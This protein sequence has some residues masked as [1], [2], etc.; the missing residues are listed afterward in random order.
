MTGTTRAAF[1]IAMALAYAPAFIKLFIS[2]MISPMLLPALAQQGIWVPVIHLGFL[3]AATVGFWG[4]LIAIMHLLEPNQPVG[5]KPR[6]LLTFLLVALITAVLLLLFAVS[7]AADATIYG[8]TIPATFYLLYATHGYTRRW[9]NNRR[10]TG[11]GQ[12]DSTFLHCRK[13]RIGALG[14]RQLI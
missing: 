13:Y 14:T 6:A 1:I 4:V 9:Q 11:G 12:D 3:I 2:F 8:L 10:C 7:R 5:L